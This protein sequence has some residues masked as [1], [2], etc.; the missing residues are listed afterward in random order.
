MIV[1][2]ASYIGKYS[3]G[4]L[5]KLLNDVFLRRPDA[6]RENFASLAVRRY[7]YSQAAANQAG[8]SLKG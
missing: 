2:M 1:Q 7:T 8:P 4:C 3:A 5:I 6:G